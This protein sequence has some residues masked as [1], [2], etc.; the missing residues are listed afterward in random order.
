MT[1]DSWGDVRLFRVLRNP[2]LWIVSA[3]FFLA[4]RTVEIQLFPDPRVVAQAK[5]QYWAQVTV[6]TS[7][8]T[9]FD[10]NGIP[11]AI[12]IP[13]I[14]FF[15]DPQEWKA[16][17]AQQLKGKFEESTIRKLSG[18]LRGRF[19][20]VARK[21]DGIRAEEL[22]QLKLEG[23]FT[24]K[25]QKRVYPH[26][27]SLSHILGYCDIDDN[28]LSGIERAWDRVLFSPPQ[29]RVVV[30]TAGG[31]TLDLLSPLAEITA[32]K[33]GKVILTVDARIQHIME[34][35]VEKA[36]VRENVSWAA[37]VCLDPN[38]GAVKGMVSWPSFDANKRETLEVSEAKRNNVIGRV[39]EPG[40]TLKPVI[41]GIA[42][43]HG[44]VS[45]GEVFHNC[46]GRI[47]VADTT[48][49][50]VQGRAHGTQTLTDV[51]VN[52][53]NV[54]MAMIGMRFRSQQMYETLTQWGFGRRTNIELPGEEEGLVY[55]PE[56]WYGAIPSNIA[57]GQGVAVTPLQL[58]TAISAIVN[59][60]TLLQPYLVQEAT[61]GSG[62]K[63]YEGRRTPRGQVLSE[64]T[65][66]WLRN[67]MR[68]VILRGTGK[69]ANVQGVSVSG[70]TGTAQ[71]AEKGKYLE[72][73][74]VA[75]F[76][77]FWPSDKPENVLLVILG[78]PK[79]GKD[80]GGLIAAPLFKE[81]VEAMLLLDA[82][83][84]TPISENR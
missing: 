7:R 1:S 5:K 40:S 65:A 74:Y 63:I 16:E 35:T 13:S 36:A 70:K 15:V 50:E 80:M 39:Y 54:G 43:E 45:K 44:Y 21:I 51:L 76:V 26:G 24:M 41:M 72:H 2:W 42:L 60:G 10:R 66:V 81:I 59:G 53:S 37:A 14:S 52:S 38:S 49:R 22:K 29:V 47:K 48:I 82:E 68:E 67:A 55:T 23:L 9:I 17:S 79:A 30:R 28:G 62:K 12:S 75:S 32:P 3:L 71:I 4:G 69:R 11:L 78:E 27:S 83:I 18:P 73:R 64:E 84:V 61:D 57:I 33:A 20:W 58:A 6:S 25:E 77:G 34:E 46:P 56:R 8:G 19:H 31:E